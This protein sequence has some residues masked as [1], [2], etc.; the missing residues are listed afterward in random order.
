MHIFPIYRVLVFALLIA[1]LVE[2]AAAQ[3][4]QQPEDRPAPIRR[5]PTAAIRDSVQQQ[6]RML[7]ADAQRR[8]D[9]E[10]TRA[11]YTDFWGIGRS[12]P[13][14]K[15]NF[16]SRQIDLDLK[17]MRA[18]WQK[19]QE[20]N[21]ALWQQLENKI[22][23]N[24]KPELERR[25]R[26][27]AVWERAFADP[28]SRA[29]AVQ[30]GSLFNFFLRQIDVHSGLSSSGELPPQLTAD[31][32]TF[33]DSMINGIRIEIRAAGGPIA[34]S[35]TN[36]LPDVLST[37]PYLLLDPAFKSQRERVVELAKVVMGPHADAEAQY[38]AAEAY[39]EA[40]QEL[41]ETFYRRYPP[42]A[43][44]SVSRTQWYR[45]NDV[46]NYLA[47]LDQTV[48]NA[49]NG[50]VGGVRRPIYTDI[51]PP[52]ERNLATLCQFM[53]RNGIRFA[54]P[55][56]QTEFVYDRLFPQFRNFMMQLEVAPDQQW[57]ES[58]LINVDLDGAV[59]DEP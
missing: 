58:A 16:E 3:D 46:D 8:K 34:V 41:S 9:L 5:S 24:R 45:L 20:R 52:D 37:Y 7:S 18:Y 23:N 19:K 31:L 44:K 47:S 54:K 51:Y 50:G 29:I 56:P 36:P 35:L 11:H 12:A 48:S 27:L 6:T 15:Q 10:D 40:F 57:M 49:A 59:R 38:L 2:P 42:S 26:A 39:S 55:A 28:R 22:E 53:L 21:V 25:A 43:R 1:L 32:P 14:L 17:K 13:F 30:N 4:N 33:D